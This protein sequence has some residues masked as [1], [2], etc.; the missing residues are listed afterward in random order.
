MQYQNIN[1]RRQPLRATADVVLR[2]GKQAEHDVRTF[3]R[4]QIIDDFV[5]AYAKWMGW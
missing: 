4:E 3:S 5:K 1:A 2:S